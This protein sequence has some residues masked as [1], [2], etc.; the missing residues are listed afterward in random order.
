MQKNRVIKWFLGLSTDTSSM[1]HG[2][3]IVNDEY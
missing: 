1:W 2:S 3:M